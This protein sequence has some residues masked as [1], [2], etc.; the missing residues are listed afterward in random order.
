MNLSLDFHIRQGLNYLERNPD[1]A[2]SCRPYFD[3]YFLDQLSLRGNVPTANHSAWDFGDVGSRFA[4]S[5]I[6][7]RK[8]LGMAEASETEKR[9]QSLLFSCFGDDGL[10]HRPPSS[11][12]DWNASSEDMHL[13]DQ[14]QTLMTLAAIYG[15]KPSP[16]VAERMEKLAQGLRNLS[17]ASERGRYFPWESARDGKWIEVD[18]NTHSHYYIGVGPGIH[19]AGLVRCA[20][21]LNRADM[22]DFAAELA[23]ACFEEVPFPLFDWTGA[24]IWNPASKVFGHRYLH[25]HARTQTL[26]GILELGI[27]RHE[28]GWIQFVRRSI[29]WLLDYCTE[30][31]WC[32]EHLPYGSNHW[33]EICT[34]ADVIEILLL[35]GNLGYTEYWGIAERFT[36]NHLV[37]T[38]H[39]DADAICAH[40]AEEPVTP[41][42]AE[43]GGD[44]ESQNIYQSELGQTKSSHTGYTTRDDVVARNLGG[45]EGA[46]WP[47]EH[48]GLYAS[49]CCS[50]RLIDALCL[51]KAHAVKESAT[52]TTINMVMDVVTDGGLKVQCLEPDAGGCTIESTREIRK[53]RVRM[54]D[55]LAGTSEIRANA[56]FELV[57]RCLIFDALPAGV[58][59]EISFP[60]RDERLSETLSGDTYEVHWRGN[61]VVDLAAKWPRVL[62]RIPLYKHRAK[63]KETE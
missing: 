53:L 44:F 63:V 14:G 61:T 37:E 17:V 29:D 40:C 10:I 56:E 47:D 32:P 62:P 36:R 54:P 15:E 52:H 33:G 57:D 18:R 19:I 51:V 28:E 20:V 3:V 11:R 41:T 59:L 1:P 43:A 39:T 55:W 34:T 26:L 5:F 6:N 12:V 24:M 13:F 50:P 21:H 42:P 30:Y 4:R 25:V 2:Q 23:E 16:E 8:A 35:L 38:Q 27:A 45:S 49:G 22:L 46:T 7:A 60:L 9:L 31:G 48:R 58:C